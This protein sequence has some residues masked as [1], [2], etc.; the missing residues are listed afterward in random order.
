MPLLQYFNANTLEHGVPWVVLSEKAMKQQTQFI[1]LKYIHVLRGP[2]QH[3]PQDN[4]CV[5]VISWRSSGLWNGNNSL[6]WHGI[7]FQNKAIQKRFLSL[8]RSKTVHISHHRFEVR[9][10]TGQRNEQAL[11]MQTCTTH[12]CFYFNLGMHDCHIS[13]CLYAKERER[14]KKE[15]WTL[16][17]HL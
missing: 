2:I 8:S 4:H 11:L 15:D 12:L 13:C 10:M 9:H 1:H 17:K 6:E 5:R 3:R 14:M 7:G 16:C